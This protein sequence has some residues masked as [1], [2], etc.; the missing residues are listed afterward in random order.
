MQGLYD[1]IH[2]LTKEE[3]RIIKM[4]PLSPHE[5][6]IYDTYLCE[7]NYSPELDQKIF[8]NHFQGVTR[9]YYSMVKRN[10]LENLILL[11]LEKYDKKP[12]YKSLRY[13]LYYYVLASKKVR[14]A[15]PYYLQKLIE[16]KETE[17]PILNSHILRILWEEGSRSDFFP[18]DKLFKILQAFL[19]DHQAL[20]KILHQYNILLEDQF[21]DAQ[22][23]DSIQLPKNIE[24]GWQMVKKIVT[25]YHNYQDESISNRLHQFLRRFEHHYQKEKQRWQNEA[26]L[27]FFTLLLRSA[28]DNGDFILLHQLTHEYPYWSSQVPRS[29]KI[30]YFALVRAYLAIYTFL[31]GEVTTAFWHIRES[32][33]Y[34]EDPHLPYV[35]IYHLLFLI[36]TYRFKEALLL[37]QQGAYQNLFVPNHFPGIYAIQILLHIW[38]KEKSVYDLSL[39]IT[40]YL[41]IVPKKK[42][43]TPERKLLRYI[44]KHLDELSKV[45][46]LSAFTP[47]PSIDPFPPELY[48]LLKLSEVWEAYWHQRNYHQFQIQ[49]WKK[50]KKVF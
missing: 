22:Q 11:L 3:K 41:T 39:L 13:L 20:N 1:F 23:L 31:E 6:I 24:K 35:Q 29:L 48:P 34:T 40:R 8:E 7:K 36:S 18:H 50:R 15:L 33:E 42:L 25:K 30:K 27:Q 32:I 17:N 26:Y 46:S 21:P 45:S 12:L 28:L 14:S 47:L 38:N 10:L 9:S 44:D 49:N 2:S 19:Q 16:V 4:N 43:Y 37:L 5:M